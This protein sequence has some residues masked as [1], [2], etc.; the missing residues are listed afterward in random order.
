MV[1]YWAATW[2]GNLRAIECRDGLKIAT[3]DAVP[4]VRVALHLALCSMGDADT[5]LPA[6]IELVDDPNLLVGLYAM[7][8]VEQTGILN[9][10]VATGAEKGLA[11]PYDGTQR[12][13]RRLK[14]KCEEIVRVSRNE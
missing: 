10:S 5:S 1:R 9:A 12:Y 14:K 11:S 4:T 8:A 3:H 13:G 2:L 6:L 7:N